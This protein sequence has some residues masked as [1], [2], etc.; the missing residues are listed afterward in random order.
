MRIGIITDIH[1]NANLLK[2]ALDRLQ[3]RQVDMIVTLGDI[4]D[5]FSPESMLDPVV[6]LLSSAGVVGVWGN[7][8]GKYCVEPTESLVE[9]TKPATLEYM[10]SL[11]P[12]LMIGDVRFS[13]I[14]HWLDATQLEDL[15]FFDGVPNTLA[16]ARKSF[17][18]T[19]ERILFSGHF[20]RWL[21]MT[22]TGQADWQPDAT[23]SF[24]HATRY[25]WWWDL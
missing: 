3:N 14:E 7:H 8:D 5:M 2:Q 11:E 20:H 10:R 9:R 21:I 13:H 12:F 24:D 16:K 19:Q 23:F 15:W 25:L 18:A 6:D 4:A 1:V 17:A 22:P